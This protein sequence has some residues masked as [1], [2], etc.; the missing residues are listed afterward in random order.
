MTPTPNSGPADVSGTDRQLVIFM[1]H[2]IS[3]PLRLAG[4]SEGSLSVYAVFWSVA[5]HEGRTQ[6]EIA[7]AT[8]LSAKT[9]SRV[10]SRIG[11]AREG[12]GW[13]KQINDEDDRRLRRL[14]LSRKGKTLLGRMLRD[15]KNVGK[16]SGRR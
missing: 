1:A 7:D 16:S 5:A 3:Q 8:G 13:I 9:V 12:L 6:V 11:M 14:F 15:M 2:A 10:I 4:H